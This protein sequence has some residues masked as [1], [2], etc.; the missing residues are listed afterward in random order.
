LRYDASS[1]DQSL[2]QIRSQLFTGGASVS[3]EAACKIIEFNLVHL[4]ADRSQLLRLLTA[5]GARPEL[6]EGEG[7]GET[8]DASPREPNQPRN[9]T[10][11][12]S[13]VCLC[14]RRR[15][16]IECGE[17]RKNGQS[18]MTWAKRF[19]VFLI[20]GFAIYFLIAEPVAA[21]NAVRFV[22]YGLALA[23]HSI[24][25]FFQSLAGY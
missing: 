15:I 18:G 20:V 22:A 19:I 8:I 1:K 11:S 24:L 14:P 7:E 23:F 9:S 5:P 25:I 16:R 2:S 4:Q 10:V 12:R 21:A 13:K 3:S 6:L 17:D